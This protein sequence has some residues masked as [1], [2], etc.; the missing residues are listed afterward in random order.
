MNDKEF[1]DILVSRED[2]SSFTI[3]ENILGMT[4][5]EINER[6]V[7]LCK[8]GI[9]EMDVHNYY[10]QVN[11]PDFTVKSYPARKWEHR[12]IGQSIVFRRIKKK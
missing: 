2:W 1:T 3:I 5:D 11:V 6:L 12:L 9:I 7:N 10:D 4:W 8:S